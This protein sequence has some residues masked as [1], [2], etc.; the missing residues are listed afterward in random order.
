MRQARSTWEQVTVEGDGV[1]ATAILKAGPASVRLIVQLFEREPDAMVL[2][3]AVNGWQEAGLEQADMMGAA[4]FELGPS[5]KSRPENFVAELVER[6]GRI[7][8]V[9][10]RRWTSDVQQ[11]A[12]DVVAASEEIT[13]VA[14]RVRRAQQRTTLADS[15]WIDFGGLQTQL[16]ASRKDLA[17]ALSKARARD[18]SPL[19]ASL[20]LV[21]L[22]SWRSVSDLL[23]A[24]ERDVAEARVTLASAL[25]KM[26]TDDTDQHSAS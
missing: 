23:A 12:A 20:P 22:N 24:L 3:F 13:R 11:R 18:S 9:A 25:G 26:P 1:V 6:H 19:L 5:M 10:A 4:R 16:H 7:D 15:E 21:R 17:T 8:D 14:L 2:A